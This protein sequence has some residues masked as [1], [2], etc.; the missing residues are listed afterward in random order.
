MTDTT[1]PANVQ[2]V[3]SP[4]AFE[5]TIL[6]QDPSVEDPAPAEA[7]R[8]ILRVSVRI[9]A[10][11]TRPGPRGPRFHVVDYDPVSR[12]VASPY[13]FSTGDGG[14]KDLFATASDQELLSDRRFHAQNLY[15]IATRTLAT[16]ET[17]LGR[18]IPWGFQSHQLYLVPHA[19][20]EANAYYTDA[21]QALL[22]GDYTPPG[23]TVFTCLSHDIIAHETTHAILDGLRQRF[24]VPGLPDQPA[25]HEAFADI[26]ALLSV[27]SMQGIVS[28]LISLR[29]GGILLESDVTTEQL[30]TL[31][32]VKMADELGDAVHGERGSGLRN[33]AKLEPTEAWKDP[34]NAEWEEPHRRGEILVAAVMRALM[35]IWRRRLDG[36]IQEHKLNR[37]RAAEEGS[38]SASHLLSMLI[39][40]IDYTPPVDFEF[41]DFLDAVLLSDQEVAPDDE[42]KYRETLKSAFEAYGLRPRAWP[43][44]PSVVPVDSYTYRDFNYVALRS[45]PEEVFRFL[46]ENADVL[47]IDQ[48]YY[49]KVEDVVPSARIGPDG[50]VVV[51]SVADYV[52][53]LEVTL[54]HAR[55]LAPEEFAS[56]EH[57]PGDTPV[58]FWGGGSIIFDQF[59]R[60]KYHLFK[61]LDD[62]SRQ[63]RRLQYLVRRGMRDTKGRY[64]FSLGAPAGMRFALLHRPDEQAGEAW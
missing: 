41:A 57:L 51:E 33:S 24:D 28:R 62:W 47:G 64:G 2:T 5:L 7:E 59:G 60:V 23:K 50:F 40:A 35:E 53:Q 17:A 21:D 48:S 22:F 43:Q 54:A 39:R 20:Q 10:R 45:E 49:L 19:F 44:A 37:E 6:A 1:I 12:Q 32:L 56:L 4:R 63:S 18:R 31:A 36:L 9:P 14:V 11:T 46:W 8:R 16:F 42:H 61:R 34:T 52:Q 30:H 58:K 27:F 38:K 15:V 13:D 26:V 3:S 55:R 29:E 25:F